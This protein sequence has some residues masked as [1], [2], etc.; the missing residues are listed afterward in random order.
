MFNSTG[1]YFSL[2]AS[3]ARGY[4]LYQAAITCIPGLDLLLLLLLIQLMQCVSV[5]TLWQIRVTM[6][7]LNNY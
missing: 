4:L 5:V 1:E 3:V 6:S 2:P 7:W